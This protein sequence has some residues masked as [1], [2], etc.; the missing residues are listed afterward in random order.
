MQKGKTK[1]ERAGMVNESWM[2]MWLL[3]A[4]CTNLFSHFDYV[5]FVASSLVL[6]A[7]EIY[8]HSSLRNS[9][10]AATQH[11]CNLFQALG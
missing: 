10:I 6:V 1:N 8:S 3:I 2:F 7:I 9:F 11:F 5:T 4:S